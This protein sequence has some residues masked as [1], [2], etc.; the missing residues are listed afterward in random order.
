MTATT[1]LK[2][3]NFINGDFEEAAS[4][5]TA[6]VINPASGDEIGTAPASGPA[7]IERAVHAARDAFDGWAATTPGE[8]A[9]ALLKIADAL[10]ARGDELARTEA[11][12]AGK[13]IEAVK[14]DEVG[15][16]VDQLRFFAGA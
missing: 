6:S 8:R 3:R 2:L 5:E 13:P 10:E 1:A 14:A 4:G 12:N 11:I 16:M 15:A 9:L 7:D